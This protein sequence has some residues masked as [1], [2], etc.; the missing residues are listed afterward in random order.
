MLFFLLAEFLE[1]HEY[2]EHIKQLVQKERELEE[3]EKRQ[4]EIERN[5]CK[6][7]ISAEQSNNTFLARNVSIVNSNFLLQ[8]KGSC[9]K[10]ICINNSLK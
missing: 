6:V 8:Y 10:C 9:D 1:A 5:T 7:R 3:Q 4:R 2:P